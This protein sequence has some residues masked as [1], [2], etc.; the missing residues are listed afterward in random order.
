MKNSN[1]GYR[2]RLVPGGTTLDTQERRRRS[3]QHRIP[4][5][6]DIDLLAY[7]LSQ[8]ERRSAWIWSGQPVRLQNVV[9]CLYSQPDKLQQTTR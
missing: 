2:L 9:P 5:Q 4:S 3:G 1:R 7:Y 6:G 8:G